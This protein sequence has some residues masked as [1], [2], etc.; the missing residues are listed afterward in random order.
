MTDAVARFSGPFL[1]MFEA[2][3]MAPTFARGRRD[4]RAGHVRSLTISSSLVV[5]QVRGPEETGAHRARIAVRAFGA[6]EWS[7]VEDELAAQARYVA[8]LLAGR[9]PA[10]IE[11]GLR[12]RRPEPAAA[13]H[14]RDGD[15]LHLRT[16][17][18]AVH[19]PR[20]DAVRGGPLV[21][22]PTRSGCS[23]G[24]AGPRDELL[25]R[26]RQLRGAA[27]VEAAMSEEVP[28]E[29]ASLGEISAFWG[30]GGT[31]SAPSAPASF[32][33][34]SSSPVP[35]GPFT[36]SSAASLPASGLD[37]P[38]AFPAPAAVRPDALLDQLDLPP[39]LAE[40]LRPAYR[41]LP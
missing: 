18:D 19:P 30:G 29:D 2:L 22:R 40:S 38:S 7:R 24:A 37:P 14:R 20:R 36:S 41:A 13:V 27:A 16:L 5:A 9:M 26:L 17:A 12:R 34:V 11:A 35:S 25:H 28:A 6:A 4:A 32:S 23:R 21:R 31:R 33:A 10:G 39:Q 3:R 8:D 1:D 15:G